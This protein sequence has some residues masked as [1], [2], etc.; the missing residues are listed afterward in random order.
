MNKSDFKDDPDY[1]DFVIPPYDCYEDDKVPPSKMPDI[2]DAKDDDDVDVDTYDQ[3]VGAHARVPIGDEIRSGKV[4]RRK[5]E[6]DGTVRGISN[7]NS[8][9]DIR[10]Y[11]IEF[12]DGR[13]DEYTANVIIENMYSQCDIEGRQYNLMEGIVD[14]KTDGH[15]FEPADMYIKHG[16]N[17]KVRKI[18]KGCNLCFEWK[19]GT[20]SWER[21]A[22]LKESNPV[23]VDDYA[24][25]K[26]LLNTPAFVW[27]APHVLKK[28]IRI[29]AAVT[30]CYHKRTD[31]FGIEDH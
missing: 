17:K 15:A 8:M 11:E 14:H 10:I 4:V 3:Y 18:T 2:D 6:L 20:T 23:E 13:S 31:K 26:S 24:A 22:D 7:S 16:S 21:L 12:T 19:Y 30:K 1:V 29:I 27:W 5:R 9:L 28:H 25:E